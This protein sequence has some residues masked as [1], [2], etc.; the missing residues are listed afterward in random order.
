M[1]KKNASIT[2]RTTPGLKAGI[3]TL[4]ATDNRSMS[5]MVEILIKLGMREFI[6]RHPDLPDDFFEGLL[7]GS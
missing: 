2:F 4:A 1:D 7:S 3:E 5:G 6:K